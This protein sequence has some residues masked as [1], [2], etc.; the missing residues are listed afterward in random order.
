MLGWSS[1][2]WRCGESRRLANSLP[3][4]LGIGRFLCEAGIAARHDIYAERRRSGRCSLSRR[5]P[6]ASMV[7]SVFSTDLH[8]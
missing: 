7:A 4:F 8:R 3:L 5:G 2:A 6:C 1:V